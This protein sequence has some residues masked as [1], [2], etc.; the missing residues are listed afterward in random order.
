MGDSEEIKVELTKTVWMTDEDFYDL[1]T[2][3][4]KFGQLNSGF[5]DHP[6]MERFSRDKA[7]SMVF[8]SNKLENT[9]PTGVTFAIL[10]NI[11]SDPP[12]VRVM[13]WNFD[14]N[15]GPSASQ[16]MQ[17]LKVYHHLMLLKK[18]TVKDLLGTHGVLMLGA[19]SD[20]GTPILSGKIRTFGVNNGVEDYLSQGLVEEELNKLVNWYSHVDNSDPVE[21]AYK[22][23]YK[24]L[25]IHPF[26]D[27]NGRMTRLLV[28][29]HLIASETPF[30]VCVTS[31]KKRSHKHCYDAIKK[32]DLLYIDRTDLY[33]LIAYSVYL[34][35]KNFLSLKKSTEMC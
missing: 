20:A 22:L 26:E 35:W 11:L 13:P 5:A 7:I 10:R 15:L 33:T 28:A 17:H 18:L 32:E 6:M 4:S 34:G 12:P 9:L 27:G 31:G 8:N 19:V 23:F 3:R 2:A 30:P 29:Y 14:G 1:V 24:F 21:V 25:K 16:L